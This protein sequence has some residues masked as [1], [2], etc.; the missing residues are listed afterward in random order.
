M[1]TQPPPQNGELMPHQTSFEE[2]LLKTLLPTKSKQQIIA[3]QVSSY[4]TSTGD[5]I[6]Q[7]TKAPED[8]PLVRDAREKPGEMPFKTIYYINLD[9]R[10]DRRER[11]EE[12]L[13]LYTPSY[14]RYSAV[15][16]SSL[17]TPP[18]DPRIQFEY[19]DLMSRHNF[20]QSF[21]RLSP[22]AQTFVASVY[23][24]HLSLMDQILLENRYGDPDALFLILEDDAKLQLGWV[25]MFDQ[26]RNEVPSDWDILRLG[27]WGAIRAEDQISINIAEARAP[28]KAN[29]HIYYP[30]MHAV[31][32]RPRTL[33]R[34]IDALKTHP[35]IDI[36]EMV[37][38]C[39][40]ELK[41]YVVVSNMIGVFD[42]HGA[43]SD[44][45][46]NE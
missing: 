34:V 4:V 26:I 35:L 21:E 40:D 11:L 33:P 36:D 44:H 42:M 12:Q 7:G 37:T 30:G 23:L 29:N 24:S 19:A 46:H 3:H 20:D 16:L 31:V 43:D 25:Q 18:T 1:K 14:K 8:P 9:H 2:S 10:E 39:C 28:F 15:R 45:P 22:E 13:R 17:S 41:S 5:V 27:T 6:G 32:V 38:T